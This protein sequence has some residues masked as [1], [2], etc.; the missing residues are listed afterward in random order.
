MRRSACVQSM[1]RSV[2]AM[3]PLSNFQRTASSS[4]SGTHHGE[5][6]C[7]Q[8][9]SCVLPRLAMSLISS[10]VA[11]RQRTLC[12]KN[13]VSTLLD[14]PEQRSALPPPAAQRLQT[15]LLLVDSLLDPV[16]SSHSSS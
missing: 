10:N 7:S 2:P 16:L 9:I 15:L 14:V 13:F 1:A 11:R 8:A 4:S 12:A 5:K 3:C 6:L